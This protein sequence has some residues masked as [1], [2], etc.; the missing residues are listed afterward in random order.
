MKTNHYKLTVVGV[1]GL[2]LFLTLVTCGAAQGQTFHVIYYFASGPDGAYPSA[3]LTMDATGNLYGIASYGG[4]NGGGTVF[5]MSYNSSGWGLTPLYSFKNSPDGE[6]PDAEVVFGA[7]GSLYGTTTLGGIGA[8]CGTFVSCGTVFNLKPS[9]TPPRS[10]L[11]MWTETVLYRFG[12]RVLDAFEPYGPVVFDPAGNMYGTTPDGGASRCQCGAVYKLAPSGG[13]WTETV[14]Y[15]FQGGTDGRWPYGALTLDQ[16]GNL[17]GTTYQG[18]TDGL[19]TVYELTR[20][21]SGWTKNILHSFQDIPEGGQPAGGVVLDQY[22]NLYGSTSAGGA[23]GGGSVFELSHSGDNWVLTVLSSFSGVYGPANSLSIDGA[24]N[25]YGTTVRDGAYEHG[26]VFKLVPGNAGWTYTSLYDFTGGTDGDS[27][28][29]KVTFNANGNL[30][31]TTVS[32]GTG[33]GGAGCG[34]VWEITP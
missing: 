23:G 31:G 4:V 13:G 20:S 8:G 22:G 26:N 7:D 29:S 21:G 9:A 11:D 1:I 12:M 30:Y 19:G 16:A 18:G 17:Y 25:L 3:G 33:C 5:K 14:I 28:Q 15:S 24:G 2:V 32:G 6:E 27:P 10:I 34:V